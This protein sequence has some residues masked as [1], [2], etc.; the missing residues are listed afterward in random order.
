MQPPNQG[1]FERKWEAMNNYTQMRGIHLSSPGQTGR[2]GSLVVSC[3]DRMG[4]EKPSWPSLR[5]N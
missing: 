4:W 1:T 5:R 3:E 2:M